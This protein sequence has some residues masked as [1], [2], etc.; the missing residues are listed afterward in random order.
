MS[1]AA[2]R[3]APEVETRLSV[4]LAGDILVN[5]SALRLVG[6]RDSGTIVGADLRGGWRDYR[7]WWINH[8]VRALLEA[9][10]GR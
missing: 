4:P 6:D 7:E 2:Q 5:G 1:H 10:A 8:V 9:Y 3:Q